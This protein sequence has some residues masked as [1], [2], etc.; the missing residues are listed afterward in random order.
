MHYVDTLDEAA[1]SVPPDYKKH[2]QG[3]SRI[4]L[5]DHSVG[6]VHMGLGVS[7]LEA[8][9]RLAFHLHSYE[10]GFFILEGQVL[11]S[12][13]GRAYQF[14]PGAYGIIPVGVPHA[15][16]NIGEQPVRWLEMLA[17]QPKPPERGRDTFFLKHESVPGAGN[18]LDLRDPR[19]R[20]LGHFADAQ[21]PPSG[22]LQMQGD[23]GGHIHGISVKMLVDRTLGAQHFT[24]FMVEFQAGGEGVIHDHPF[25]EAYFILSGEAEAHLDGQQYHVK[26]GDVVWTGVGSTHG[27]LNRGTTPIRWLETQA[28][29]PPDQQS[30][31]F[32]SDWEYLA[33]KLSSEEEGGIS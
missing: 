9:G 5:V 31:R 19:I 15:W 7:K 23:P 8:G 28:P 1:F 21:M 6:S 3:Y 27:F 20:Y 14:G 26:A 18:P 13:D 12:V 33:E 2:S 22:K 17:V 24:M 32:P 4:A 29:Q 10:E 11:G 25:E 16:H 30:F